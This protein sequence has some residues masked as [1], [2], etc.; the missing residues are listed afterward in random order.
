MA[1][2][3]SFKE[4]VLLLQ[5]VWGQSPNLSAVV[6]LVIPTPNTK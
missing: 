5:L 3:Y 4:C 6:F 1:P 2:V